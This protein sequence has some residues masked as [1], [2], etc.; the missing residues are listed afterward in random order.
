MRAGFGAS[1]TRGWVDLVGHVTMV[2]EASTD[3]RC[4]RGLWLAGIL[5]NVSV[6]A[7][8]HESALL[9]SLVRAIRARGAGC[10]CDRARVGVPCHSLSVAV[11][12]Q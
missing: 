5:T 10:A 3:I 9:E 8:A 6:G 4:V 2:A 12:T 1:L 11:R 7:T